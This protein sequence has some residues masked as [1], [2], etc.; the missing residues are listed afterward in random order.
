MNSCSSPIKL[1]NKICTIAKITDEPVVMKGGVHQFVYF[2]QGQK[3]SDVAHFDNRY[4]KVNDMFLVF[5]D[6]SNPGKYEMTK[7]MQRIFNAREIQKVDSINYHLDE[8][9]LNK[10]DSIN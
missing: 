3:Y 9:D 2:Y 10:L 1:E 7:P 5:I 4:F 8:Y 6:K